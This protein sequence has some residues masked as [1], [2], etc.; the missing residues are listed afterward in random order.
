MSQIVSLSVVANQLLSVDFDEVRYDLRFRTINDNQMCVDI[1]INDVQVLSGQRVI[2]NA[3]LIP[4]VYL[5]DS[6]GNFFFETLDNELPYWDKF[7]ISQRL[8]YV[9]ADELSNTDAN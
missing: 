8:I 5:A 4:Y 2:A 1:T 6:G 7:N 3:P 9:T